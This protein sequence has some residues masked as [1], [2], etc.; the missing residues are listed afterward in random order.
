MNN[1]ETFK[2]TLNED[3]FCP[4]DILEQKRVRFKVTS[5]VRVINS[6]WYHKILNILSLGVF[7]KKVYIYEV[8]QI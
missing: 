5:G 2:I 6:R 7:F 3:Y 1:T 8:K 4:N